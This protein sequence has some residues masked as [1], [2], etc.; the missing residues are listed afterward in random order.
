VA[1]V[2]TCVVLLVGAVLCVRSLMNAESIDPGFDTR[3]EAVAT[4]DPGRIGYSESQGRAFYG[5]LLE[6]VQNLPGVTAASWVSH[7]PLG[8]AREMTSCSAEGGGK[9]PG[10]EGASADVLRVGS[11]YFEAMGMPMSRG[12]DFTVEE[13]KAATGVVIVNEAMA[14]QLWPGA[15]ALGQHVRFG[16]K[17][18]AEVIGVVRTGKYRTLGEDPLPLIYL[19]I[20]YTPE[21]TLVVRSMND[22][23]SLLDPIRREIEAVDRN[24]AATDL[25]TMQQHMT[26]PLFPARAIGILLGVFGGLAMVLAVGGLYGVISYTTSQRTR[27]IG[28]R[29]ALGA[30]HKDV[31]KMVLK[32]GVSMAT[33]GIAIGAAAGYGVT[34]V[35]STLL[36]GVRAD[37][38]FTFV[39]VA[40]ALIGVTLLAC[41]V[42][43]RRAMSVDPTIALR[44][45]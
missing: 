10:K 40:V 28:I 39:G 3:H 6:G 32:H 26:L 5:R 16:E 13:S 1:Q 14:R 30:Q 19:P 45:E 43:A 27:E 2:A 22:P 44:Y 4:L 8:S 11:R 24:L 17:S 34:R 42:P 21:A 33:W 18:E 29:V 37:D 12:R 41:Y 7:L 25:E 31:A 38:P 9:A 23:R 15:D 20:G 35:L 36:Y